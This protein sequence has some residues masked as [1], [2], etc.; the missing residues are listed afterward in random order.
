MGVASGSSAGSDK[1]GA[2]KVTVLGTGTMGS[3]FAANLCRAGVATTVWNRTAATAE[4]LAAVGATV[5]SD[6]STAVASA[7][8][9]ITM[10][11]DA[12]AITS[13][14]DHQRA[15]DAFAHGAA[16]VQMG[17]IG[18]AGT[19]RMA[20]LVAERRPDVTFVDAPVSGSKGPAER[21]ELLILASGPFT[22]RTRL[23]PLFDALG[24]R[25]LWLGDAGQ[26]MR[27]K[28]V[29]NAWL[30]FVMEGMAETAALADEL[31]VTHAQLEEALDGSPLATTWA[32]DKL[33]R[34]DSGDYTPE[35]SL[36]WATK[37]VGLALDAVLHR[38]PALA[39]IG[40][41]WRRAVG[42]GYGSLDV[43]A[44]RP[45]LEPQSSRAR[46]A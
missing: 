37:D 41:Q 3:A 8:A 22:E 27:L 42:D 39:A 44:A 33:A 18:L 24:R 30:A 9:V 12:S 16:L 38:L 34:I 15:L 7:D 10:L 29:L 14:L 31:G 46:S 35:F 1:N 19:D 45:A 43:S 13:V 5:A 28:L 23:G 25:T 2:L 32:L 11:P 6:P 17:T 36:A 40:V 21:G 26:G 4:P 20:A